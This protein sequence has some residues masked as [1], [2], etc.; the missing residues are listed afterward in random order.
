MTHAVMIVSAAS[1]TKAE[2]L[3]QAMGWGLD[4]YTVKLRKTATNGTYWG[5]ATPVSDSFIG[6]YQAAMAGQPIPG[7]PQELLDVVPL[8]IVDLD[9]DGL[10][11]SPLAHFQAVL[12]REG[13][14]PV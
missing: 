12:T 6:L 5:L 7:V 4:N 1:Q 8:L 9:E 10:H 14:E 2:A 3:G 11:P 13:L